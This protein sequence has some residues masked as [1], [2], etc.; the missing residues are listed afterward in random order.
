MNSL[1]TTCHTF[2]TT[3]RPGAEVLGRAHANVL[4]FCLPCYQQSPSLLGISH[5]DSHPSPT[6]TPKLVAVSSWHRL[7]SGWPTSQRASVSD[8]DRNP[9]QPC[10][11]RS[12]K[13]VSASWLLL[14]SRYWYGATLSSP[15]TSKQVVLPY[16]RSTAPHPLL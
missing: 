15:T 7:A 9:N 3:R 16:H 12:M 4:Q 11:V 8:P 2:R 6:S 13:D 10:I 14:L 5:T 1:G